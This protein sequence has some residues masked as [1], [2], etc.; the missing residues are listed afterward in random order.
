MLRLE[1]EAVEGEAGGGI[2][3]VTFWALV[4]KRRIS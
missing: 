1:G 2:G 4:S 3:Q